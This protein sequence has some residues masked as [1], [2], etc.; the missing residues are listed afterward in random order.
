MNRKLKIIIMITDMNYYE[1]GLNDIISRFT[2]YTHNF[3][4]WV[5]NVTFYK[6]IVLHEN[7][8][9]LAALNP[10]SISSRVNSTFSPLPY[11]EKKMFFCYCKIPAF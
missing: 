10:N 5:V 11:G 7:L 3:V 6:V 9:T 4:Y 8:I 2:N 1:M